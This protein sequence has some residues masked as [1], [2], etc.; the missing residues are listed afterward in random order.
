MKRVIIH[1][2]DFGYSS[3]V[4]QGIL[5]GMQTGRITSASTLTNFLNSTSEALTL[6]RLH[7]LDVG[8]HVNLTEGVPLSSPSEIPSLISSEGKFHPLKTFILKCYLRQI[9]PEEIFREL[10]AQYEVFEKFSI[11]PSHIDGHEHVH[12]F[13]IISP[14]VRKI[15]YEHSIPFVRLPVEEGGVT[16]PR[17][18]GRKFLSLQPGSKKT[19]WKISESIPAFYGFSLATVKDKK[20]AW[21]ELFAKL[22]SFS[23]VMVHPGDADDVRDSFYN[24]RVDE[25]NFLLS[26]DFKGLLQKY[27]IKLVSF[28]YDS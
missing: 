17:W 10:S 2:D 4:N 21:E 12:V 28:G 27:E 15:A 23:E 19:F 8:W 1:A 3:S 13:P 25:L 5:K 11:K 7:T 22:P 26:E 20:K 24:S 6:A 16:I 14:I 9:S 18:M